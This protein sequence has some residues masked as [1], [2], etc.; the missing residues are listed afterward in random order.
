[1]FVVAFFKLPKTMKIDF[2]QI[3][4]AS[5][6]WIAIA[7]QFLEDDS[8]EIHY[9]PFT[10]NVSEEKSDRIDISLPSDTHRVLALQL[11]SNDRATMRERLHVRPNMD[12]NDLFSN[13]L[14]PAR[15][16]NSL[17][18]VPPEQRFV[19]IISHNAK[20]SEDKLKIYYEDKASNTAYPSNGYT[21][22]GLI[23]IVKKKP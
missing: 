17:A 20:P 13:Q 1:M 3:N 7:S 4:F 6:V 23:A 11:D 10:K 8:N 12:N 22:S 18:S 2:T 14:I 5:D 15:Q 9:V 19:S 21:I 16:F